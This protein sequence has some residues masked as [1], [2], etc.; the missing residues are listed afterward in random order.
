MK[1]LSNVRFRT[2]Q[3]DALTGRRVSRS[4]WR[5]NLFLDAGLN[6]LA[7]KSGGL[8]V[9]GTATFNRCMA[10][11]GTNANSFASGAITFTQSTT[12]L[13][14]SSGF[15][16][17]AMVNGIF[18][19]G[20]GSGGQEVYITAFTDSTHVTV[21]VSQTVGTPTV[22]TVWMVQQTA[23]Q[24]QAM[25]TD[26]F[27]TT[28]GANQT[29]YSNNAV[30]HQKTFKFAVQGGTTNVNEIGWGA[31]GSTTLV[32]GRAV[33]GS[34]EVVPNTNFLVVQLQLIFT[35]TPSVPTAVGNVGTNINTAGNL[36]I[37]G[38]SAAIT[39]VNSDGT[40]SSA[41]GAC[42]EAVGNSIVYGFYT[43]TITQNATPANGSTNQPNVSTG[44][45]Q[46]A[47][48]GVWVYVGALTTPGVATMTF[49]SSA[50]T[51]GQSMKGLCLQ[52]AG[53]FAAVDVQFTTPQAA[54]TGSFQPV[55]VWQIVFGRNLTN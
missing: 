1:I 35:Y 21:S 47:T 31:G 48:N 15:F 46:I 55:T 5:K 16:T 7:N 18:K 29:T 53:A 4:R 42:L 20:T 54:P 8:G 33:L 30:T 49:N 38:F 27:I 10:G 14:A 52:V 13:T 25:F 40:N 39:T 37:E 41:S 45:I 11:T 26:S 12:T 34:T 17:S 9:L 43:A 2:A 51:T 19:F 28:A 50:N 44:F 24:T 32:G 6:S 3:Y 36:A 23:L 22:G